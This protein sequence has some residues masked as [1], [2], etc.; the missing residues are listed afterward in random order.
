GFTA[1][2]FPAAGTFRIKLHPHAEHGQRAFVM[3]DDVQHVIEL[4]ELLDHDSDFRAR[5]RELDKLLVLESVEHEQTVARLFE[6][7][8]RVELSF[9]TGFE[10]EVVTR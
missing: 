1:R 2:L 7:E 8:R 6:R 5:K 3:L 9:R 4:V 10:S